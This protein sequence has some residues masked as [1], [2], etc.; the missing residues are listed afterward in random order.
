MSVELGGTAQLSAR[1]HAAPGDGAMRR[2]PNNEQQIIYSPHQ[3]RTASRKAETPSLSREA[4]SAMAATIR[5]PS[6]P[7]VEPSFSANSASPSAG[8]AFPQPPCTG[9]REGE[10]EKEG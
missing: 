1:T 6:S 10:R 5:L 8:S 9:K 4:R 2:R 7:T 3:R